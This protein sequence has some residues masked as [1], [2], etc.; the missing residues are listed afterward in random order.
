ML[1]SMGL[2]RIVHDLVTEQQQ[3]VKSSRHQ[4]RLM[5]HVYEQVLFQVLLTKSLESHQVLQLLVYRDISLLER[6][7][8]RPSRGD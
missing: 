6:A 2:Q 5:W 7:V 1:Q 8:T 4:L 3:P